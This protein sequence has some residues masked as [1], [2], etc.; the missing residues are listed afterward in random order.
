MSLVARPHEKSIA[1]VLTSCI[2]F[3]NRFTKINLIDQYRIT[4]SCKSK[5]L[6][7]VFDIYFYLFKPRVLYLVLVFLYNRC[8]TIA[9][10]KTRKNRLPTV[11][12]Y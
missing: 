6:K 3:R 4:L 7:T 2:V 9:E 8:K 5:K 12:N 1:I 10:K 11:R